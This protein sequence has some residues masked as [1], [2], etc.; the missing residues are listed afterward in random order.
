MGGA[1]GC[2][3]YPLGVLVPVLSGGLRFGAI[4]DSLCVLRWA[5]TDFRFVGGHWF[6]VADCFGSQGLGSGRVEPLWFRNRAG[7]LVADRAAVSDWVV[8]RDGFALI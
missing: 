5:Y 7:R 8:A 3:S 1:D 4:F 6:T 2:G